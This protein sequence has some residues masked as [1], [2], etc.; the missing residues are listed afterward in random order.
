MRDALRYVQLHEQTHQDR[1]FKLTYYCVPRIYLASTG[2]HFDVHPGVISLH[3]MRS[4]CNLTFG[5]AIVRRISMIR[6][7]N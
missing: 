5:I 4:M 6:E 1:S 2:N 3:R 7:Q